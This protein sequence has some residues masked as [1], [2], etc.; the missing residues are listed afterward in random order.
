M[1]YWNDIRIS[2]FLILFV[3]V[4]DYTSSS[5]LLC[6]LHLYM[7]ISSRSPSFSLWI[8]TFPSILILTYVRN[9]SYF[10]YFSKRR[11][12]PPFHLYPHLLSFSH[13]WFYSKQRCPL[14]IKKFNFA[15]KQFVNVVLY[16][17]HPSFWFPFRVFWGSFPSCASL[18]LAFFRSPLFFV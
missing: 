2:I 14:R 18:V 8:S 17:H 13:H 3:G 6:C 10:T 11:P 9:S 4:E 16:Y 12:P 5:F 1:W 7:V 15:V